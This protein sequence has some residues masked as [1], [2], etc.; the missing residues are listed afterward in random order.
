MQKKIIINRL[1]AVAARSILAVFC[2]GM[3]TGATAYG[4]TETPEQQLFSAAHRLKETPNF[5]VKTN[6]LY[7][8]ATSPNLGVEYRFA[9]KWTVELPVTVNPWTYNKDENRKFKFVLVQPELRFWTC[10]EFNG[11]FFGL[12]GHY[13]IFNVS[14]LPNPPFT[15]TMNQH[16]YQGWLIG[17]GLSYGVQWPIS[18]RWGLEAEIGAGYARLKYD[19]FPCDVCA[20]QIKTDVIKDYWGITR[21]GLSL[22]YFIF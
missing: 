11:H 20:R 6:M 8:L 13:A 10:E 4:Q 21:L 1:I 14:S 18:A 2:V 12:H 7:N 15:I 22:V 17:A 5:T 3:A 9:R 19:Q 16:R